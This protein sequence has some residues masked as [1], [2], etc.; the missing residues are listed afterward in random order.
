[1]IVYVNK[2]KNNRHRNI[3]HAEFSKYAKFHKYLLQTHE[4]MK[5][6]TNQIVHQEMYAR[7]EQAL[8]P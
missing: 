1:M 5:L 4:N 6:Q 3:Y 8:A 7:P 2:K